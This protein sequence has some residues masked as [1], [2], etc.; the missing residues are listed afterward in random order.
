MHLIIL[1][2]SISRHA[3]GLLDA[4]RGLFTNKNFKDVELQILSYTDDAVQEDLH[5]WN[6]LDIKLFSPGPFLYSSKI[7]E[8]LLKSGA[9]IYHQEGLWRFSHLLMEE[10]SKRVGRPIVCTPHGMLD[11]FIIRNQ[12]KAKR[13]IA[14]LFFDK[15]L[16]SVSCF[17]A[18]CQKELEDIR[19]YGLKQPIAIIPNG[20]DLPNTN[21]SFVKEDDKRHL[22]YL[23]RLHEKKGVDLLLNAIGELK[24]EGNDHLT[25]WHIDIV[26]WDHENCKST[27]LKI[28]EQFGLSDIVTFHGGLFGEEK[29]KMYAMCD[30]YIL[31]SH[32]EGLPMT[33][34]EAWAWHKPVIITQE[35]HI[36]E[37]FDANAAIKIE[38][39][40]DSVKEGIIKLLSMGDDELNNMGENGYNLVKNHFSWDVA[41]RKMIELYRWLLGQQDKP[42]FVY[43]E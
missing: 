43:T 23:G 30:A 25:Y 2:D 3:G 6:N 22:L 17:Q 21:K 8:N 37:G 20:I 19:A 16:R 12:G 28:V 39:N 1:T 9:D 40:K 11:P 4:V 38:D 14:K 18:L 31:P 10:W 5:L 13:I 35:C 41:A 26:G 33:V 32:G 42:D 34:L 27:L 36:P 7:K 15:S 29:E 24:R